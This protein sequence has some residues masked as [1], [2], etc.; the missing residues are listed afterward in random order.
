V[1]I[2]QAIAFGELSKPEHADLIR[3]SITDAEALSPRFH[4]I[5]TAELAVEVA[6]CCPLFMDL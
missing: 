2:N 3:S 1:L 5:K 6:V 4:G